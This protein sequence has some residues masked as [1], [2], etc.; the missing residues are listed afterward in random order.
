MRGDFGCS[1]VYSLCGDIVVG[2]AFGP[3]TVYEHACR[4]R[5]I[6]AI[7]VSQQNDSQLVFCDH[8]FSSGGSYGMMKP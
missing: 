3:G 8:C 7:S 4:L 6:A 1:A 2:R 5:H